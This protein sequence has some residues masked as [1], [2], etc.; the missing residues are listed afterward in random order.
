MKAEYKEFRD[1]ILTL[2]SQEEL[3]ALYALFN[4]EGVRNVLSTLDIN[5]NESLIIFRR[6]TS[7]DDLCLDE[8]FY[9][10]YI[11]A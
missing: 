7:S 10:E 5:V 9:E 11:T 2:E 3:D 1:V 6:Y 4:S 8:K